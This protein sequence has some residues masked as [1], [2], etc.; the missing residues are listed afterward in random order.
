MDYQ[1]EIAQKGKLAKAAAKKL[2]IAGTNV[3]NNALLTMAAEL[4]DK[5]AE[6]LA[7]NQE[8]IASGQANGLGKALLDRLLLTPQRIEDMADGLRQIAGLPDPIGEGMASWTRPNGLQINKIRVPLGVVGII[9]EA[10]PNVTVDAAGLCL[11]SGNAVILRGGSEAIRSNLAIAKILTEAVAKADLPEAV[12]QLIETT[13]RQAV[14]VMLKANQYIDVLIPRG[15]AG[16]IKTVVE[17]ATVP[18]IETG[19]GNCHVYIDSDADLRKAH[20]IVLNAKCQR[21]GVCNALETLLVHE[22]VAED[23]LPALLQDLASAG[24]ELR[25][26][27]ATK[28]MYDGCALATDADWGTEYLD[29]ILAVKIVRDIEEAIEHIV[30]Y[31]S[32]HSEAII[33]ENYSRSRKFLAEVDAAAVYVNASTRFT[34]G[35]EFGFGA[36]IGI[37]TQKL[38]ARGPMGLEELTSIKYVVY[39]DG[40]IR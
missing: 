30:L 28:A 3:K 39:G 6:I 17:N 10:R 11:K 23:F 19:T 35:F 12:I 25:G 31:S 32:G 26:C 16:L 14:Q 37:S 9:Y 38:H 34:D 5:Q 33:T 8:D 7:A 20:P 27:Q 15:G 29:L 1:Q 21:P 22:Q 36:E 24:V 18:V 40:Q 4:V 2:A 13:D